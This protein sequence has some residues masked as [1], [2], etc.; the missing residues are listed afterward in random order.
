MVLENPGIV[1]LTPAERAGNGALC[2]TWIHSNQAAA[3]F[4]RRSMT[5]H[6]PIGVVSWDPHFCTRRARRLLWAGIKRNNRVGS[7]NLW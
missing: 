1:E 6:W 7:V 5:P 4:H 2:K 3:I